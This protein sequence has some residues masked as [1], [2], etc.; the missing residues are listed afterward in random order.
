MIRRVHCTAQGTVQGVYFR[1]SAK[2]K[3][4]E[5][6]LTGYVQN[7]GTDTV[8][9]VAEGDR[10]KTELFLAWFQHGPD[11]AT[12]TSFEAD[13]KPAKGEFTSFTVRWDE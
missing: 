6:G 8:E 1:E 9:A 11:E 3:A 7:V 10:A 2:D 12:V 5:L 4:Q 13:I